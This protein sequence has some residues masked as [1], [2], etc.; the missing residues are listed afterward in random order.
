M[1][2]SRLMIAWMGADGIPRSLTCSSWVR[3]TRKATE[4]RAPDAGVAAHFADGGAVGQSAQLGVAGE[5]SGGLVYLELGAV[6]F[7]GCEGGHG[8]LLSAR[9][10]GVVVGAD[11]LCVVG[12]R[13]RSEVGG[14]LGLVRGSVVGLGAEL[15]A[16][17][18]V[19][20][21][22]AGAVVGFPLAVDEPAGD[23]DSAA[24]REVS[25]AGVS[26]G[27]MNIGGWFF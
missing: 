18:D 19:V 17:D 9:L 22:A 20:L 11:G 23:R 27:A 25:G 3:L 12:A 8:G 10:D 2:P 4:P 13:L 1:S 7:D 16:A 6:G 14:F 21:G 26:L 15:D 5:S 24:L